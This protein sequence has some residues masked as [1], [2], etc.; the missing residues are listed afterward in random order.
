MIGIA[1]GL[2]AQTSKKTAKSP[3]RQ[4]QVQKKST[5]TTVKKK[6]TTAQKATTG[7][8]AATTTS[9]KELRS[10]REQVQKKIAQNEKQLA[11]TNQSVKKGLADLTM[12]NGQVETQQRIVTTM[13]SKID[14]LTRLIDRNTKELA[15]LK[16]QLEDKKDKYRRSMLYLYRNRKDENKLLFILSSDNFTQALRRYRYVREYAKYQRVQGLIVQKKEEEVQQMQNALLNNKKEQTTLLAG[17][18][19]ENKKLQTRQAEQQKA[20]AALKNKQKQIQTVLEADRKTIAQLNGKI[21]Y[22][23]QLA[24]EQERKRREE[25]ERKRRESEQQTNIA[26]QQLAQTSGRKKTGKASETVRESRKS[27]PMQAFRHNDKEYKLSQNFSSNKGKLPMPITGPYIITAHYGKYNMQ[28]V[29]GVY[30][31][32]KGINITAQGSANARCIFDGEVSNIFSFGG[33][34]NV[35]VRHGSYISVYCN[36]SAVSVSRGQHV[37]TR[38]SIG[39]IARDASGRYTLHFQ[40]RKETSILNPESWLAR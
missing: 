23:V 15:R 31:D 1:F 33:M 3:A 39:S 6:T 14:S 12:L 16:A 8:K 17:V 24:I 11:Q 9:L 38:Q 7:K 30:L 13:H 36:L 10:Q 25:E 18:E 37:S 4:T 40:L 34:M 22:F 27:E 5:A 26:A 32:N 29:K 35:L 28:G 20:V 2:Q 19:E 21:E